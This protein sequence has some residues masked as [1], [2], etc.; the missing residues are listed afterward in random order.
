MTLQGS[1]GP[2]VRSSSDKIY[3]PCLL[4]KIDQ[5][6]EKTL[7]DTVFRCP[8]Q[9]VVEKRIGFESTFA[10]SDTLLL[11]AQDLFHLFD[12]LWCSVFRRQMGDLGF[13]DFPDVE[14]VANVVIRAK[15][16]CRQRLDQSLFAR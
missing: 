15:Q 3:F 5:G 9:T 12:F 11:L 14:D 13:D 1:L 8:G 4:Q 10:T 16:R 7:H 6:K 2:R